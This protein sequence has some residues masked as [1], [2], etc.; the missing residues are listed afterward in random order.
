MTCIP[1]HNFVAPFDLKMSLPAEGCNF[2]TAKL[3]QQNETSATYKLR[4]MYVITETAWRTKDYSDVMP[5]SG[6][7]NQLYVQALADIAHVMSNH[8]CRFSATLRISTCHCSPVL[9]TWDIFASKW[10]STHNL[11]ALAL[12]RGW[13]YSYRNLS[14]FQIRDRRSKGR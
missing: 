4:I 6:P 3:P 10:L 8:W 14:P 5:K 12:R 2:S 11:A 1:T 7:S 13:G 9:S